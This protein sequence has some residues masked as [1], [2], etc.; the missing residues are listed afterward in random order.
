MRDVAS[1][2]AEV[3]DALL[4]G[5]PI[6]YV[7]EL[8]KKG[9]FTADEGT[10]VKAVASLHAEF[11]ARLEG[12]AAPEMPVPD[13]S[14]LIATHDFNLRQARASL[15]HSLTMVLGMPIILPRNVS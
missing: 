2:A 12:R 3:R 5:N 15:E 10:Y 6:A 1:L 4:S 7:H 11:L 9:Y 13:V 8:K 14:H